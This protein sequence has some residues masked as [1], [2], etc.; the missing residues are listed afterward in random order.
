[1]RSRTEARPLRLRLEQALRVL[2]IAALVAAAWPWWSGGEPVPPRELVAEPLA[3]SAALAGRLADA[4]RPSLL[5]VLAAVPDDTT[6]AL[7][8]AG[9]QVGALAAW[10]P[11]GAGEPTGSPARALP[12]FALSAEAR[13]A[14]SG[15]R[16]VR[17]ASTDPRT[18]VLA[19]SLGWLDSAVVQGATAW[20]LPGEGTAFRVRVDGGE[21]A[22]P[23]ARV[24]LPWRVRLYATPGWEAQ[25]ATR[26]LEEAGWQVDAELPV[27]PRVS[28]RVGE[29]ATPDTA[30]YAAVIALDSTAWRDAA[31]IARFVQRGGGL[32]LFPKAADGAPVVL[33]RAGAVGPLAPGVPGAVRTT[34]PL[35]G[36]S[37]RPI[38]ALRDDA[39]VLAR[40]TAARDSGVALAAR[41]V[42]VGRVMQVGWMDSWEWRQLGDSTSVDAHRAWWESLLVRVVPRRVTNPL[43]GAG[44]GN[45]VPGDPLPGNAAPLADLVARLG[46]PVSAPVFASPAAP[47]SPL[48]DARWAAVALLALLAEWWLRRLRGA[49]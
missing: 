13:P 49:V 47:S 14:P 34:Q 42:G 16:V 6:R 40:R 28:V 44:A 11:R 10:Q 36:L 43:A 46:P 39:V 15:G 37:F 22:V 32:V 27:A 8:H 2:A 18:V 19:D 29:P 35:D 7:L 31:A 20:S 17:L 38:T 3:G 23:V 41:R 1:M 5:V 24:Q 4:S 26:A 9:A 12:A 45:A 21:A 33:P 25:F 48:P 30:R